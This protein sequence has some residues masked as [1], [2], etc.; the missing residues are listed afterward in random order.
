MRRNIT[1]AGRCAIALAAAGTATA[2]IAAAAPAFASQVQEVDQPD[3]V[4][5]EVQT[6]NGTGCPVK[7]KD[8]VY[9]KTDPDKTGFTIYYRTF[10]A[11][12]GPN[13]DPTRARQNCVLSVLVKVPAGFIFAVGSVEQYGRAS[14]KS[15]VSADVKNSYW[16]SG[17]PVTA[18]TSHSVYPGDGTWQFTDVTAA[19]VWS[20]CGI[21]RNLNINTSLQINKPAGGYTGNSSIVMKKTNADVSTLYHLKWDRC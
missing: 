4:T 14:L 21:E 6:I 10:D 5:L 16:F 19:P 17:D 1:R 12:A 18:K 11:V 15:G 9:L 7:D 8:S 20:H 13:V 2:L 3:G